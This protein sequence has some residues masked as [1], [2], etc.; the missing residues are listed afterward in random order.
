[1]KPRLIVHI[2]TPKTGTSSIQKS[3]FDARGRLRAEA[4]VHYASTDRGNVHTKHISVTRACMSSDANKHALEFRGLM[5]DFERSGCEVMIVS[6][7]ELSQQK[8][9]ISHFFKR[10]VPHFD[11]HVICYLRRQDYFI[12]SL[13][14]Q[15]MRMK[16]YQGIPPIIEFWRDERIRERLNYH[17]LLTWWQDVPAKVTALDF[18]AAVKE[19]G[20]LPSFM[21]AAELEDFGELPDKS[22]NTSSDMRLMLTLCM[23]SKY[24]V[25]NDHQRLI[26]GLTRSARSLELRGVLK[27]LKHT[28]GSV[29]RELLIDSCDVINEALEEDFGVTFG[30]ERPKEPDEPTLA[31][32]AEYLFTL[33]GEMPLNDGIRLL[34]RC[35]QQL[36]LEQ[37]K[38]PMPERKA[39]KGKP[40]SDTGG[41]GSKD[42]KGDGGGKSDE[43]KSQL[44]I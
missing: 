41:K 22:A 26:Q 21:R 38:I 3:L 40:S 28:L 36:K 17:R 24:K 34:D 10:F 43:L 11:L 27:P 37:E 13:Y 25:E 29:E 31:P 8:E 2:G 16:S 6:E 1:M 18:S 23:L 14:N 5:E 7:E 30:E 12:E 19:D 42:K 9:R 15:V 20:L 35:R 39:P 4:K 32:D 33:L 44:A